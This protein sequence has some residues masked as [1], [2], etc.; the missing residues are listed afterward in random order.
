MIDRS[1]TVSGY[2]LF[3]VILGIF[4]GVILLMVSGCFSNNKDVKNAY[5]AVRAY[6]EMYYAK[7]N[8]VLEIV[9]PKVSEIDKE[10]IIEGKTDNG[11]DKLKFKGSYTFNPEKVQVEYL[12]GETTA[13]N[14]FEA[15]VEIY[16]G[17][18]NVIRYDEEF[19]VRLFLDQD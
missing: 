14:N 1:Q 6:Q 19:E 16:D 2:V 7:S 11:N 5:E 13:Q 9:Y 8:E 15:V 10:N 12:P 4:V 3:K 17:K 18:Y